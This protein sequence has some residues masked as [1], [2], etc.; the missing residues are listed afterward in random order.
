M[1]D[2]RDIHSLSDFQ[3]NT[4]THLEHLK[5]TGRPEVLTVH[6]QAEVVIQHAGA[7]QKLLDTVAHAATIIGIQRGLEGMYAGTGESAED[8][9]ASIEAEFGIPEA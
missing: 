7:Y 3:R 9:F 5:K 1:V 2:L 6:G 8:A 4:R